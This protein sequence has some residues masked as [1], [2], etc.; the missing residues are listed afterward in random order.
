[1]DQMGRRCLVQNGFPYNIKTL[2]IDIP[3][4]VDKTGPF[5][6]NVVKTYKIVDGPDNSINLQPEDLDGPVLEEPH[7]ILDK[8]EIIP[9]DSKG[10]EE[11]PKKRRPRD[12]SHGK[13]KKKTRQ[14][15]KPRVKKDEADQ[16][17]IEIK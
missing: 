11:S 12:L 15:R 4:A 3:M 16:G 10:I 14:K 2:K 9:Y 5:Y 13:W 17:K 7:K 8:Q 6:E 1:M